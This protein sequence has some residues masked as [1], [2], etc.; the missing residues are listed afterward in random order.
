MRDA[1]APSPRRARVVDAAG[2]RRRVPQWAVALAVAVAVAA[3]A[4]VAGGAG[5]VGSRAV[6]GQRRAAAEAE[7]AAAVAARETKVYTREEFRLA[8]AGKTPAELLA[9]FGKPYS[10]AETRTGNPAEWT[11]RN[12]SFDPV[13]QKTDW[14]AEVRFLENGTVAYVHFA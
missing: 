4:A 6:K 12:R 7:A 10:T 11:Y 1:D 3:A 9:T 14:T 2:P 8:A 13:S 5:V